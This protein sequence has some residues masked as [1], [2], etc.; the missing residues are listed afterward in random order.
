MTMRRHGFVIRELILPGLYVVGLVLYALRLHRL[1]I[2]LRRRS[3]TVL[4][5]HACETGSTPFIV[6]QRYVLT[7]EAFAAQIDFLC[8]VYNVVDL[9]ALEAGA[10]LPDRALAITIDD[11]LRSVFTHMLP[12]LRSH[13]VPARV[14]LVT[15]VLNNAGLIWMHELAWLLRTY[16]AARAI[17]APVL[18]ASPDAPIETFLTRARDRCQAMQVERLLTQLRREL[19]YDPAQV[20][21]GAELYLGDADLAELAK[22]G[23]SFGNHTVS[24]YDLARLDSMSCAAE[25]RG[26]AARLAQVPGAVRSLA[27]P[28]GRRTEETRQLALALGIGSLAEVGGSN[29]RFDRTRIARVSVT[30]QSVAGLFAQ[31][32]LVEPAKAWLARP[33][34]RQKHRR[35][36]MRRARRVA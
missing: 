4:A 21:A 27:F 16:P 33:R 31:M 19:G 24:H 22:A 18:G 6:G 13:A 15:G 2:W 28:F 5:Y 29:A 9:A 35:G 23:V 3:P 20:A 17:A 34:G 25:I 8:S 14:Y 1:L 26:A 7:P 12:A 30:H 36:R 11:G 10:A 32:A